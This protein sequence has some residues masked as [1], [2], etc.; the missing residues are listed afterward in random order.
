MSAVVQELLPDSLHRLAKLIGLRATMALVEHWGGIRVYIP[1]QV[2]PDHILV[3]KLGMDATRKLSN[4][5]G[6]ETM[7]VPRAYHAV[8]AALY[9]QIRHEYH[10]LGKSAAKLARK[11]GMTERWVYAIVSTSEVDKLGPQLGLL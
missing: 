5:F 2:E 7:D 11:Y 8:K 1:E 6:S 10:Q 3:E 4:A 9:R